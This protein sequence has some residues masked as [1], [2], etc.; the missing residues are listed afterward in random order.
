MSVVD[1]TKDLIMF[2]DY[3]LQI[4]SM[5]INQLKL[6][7]KEEFKFLNEISLKDVQ[8]YWYTDKNK[9]VLGG[10]HFFSF[11]VIYINEVKNIGKKQWKFINKAQKVIQMFPVILHELCHYWQFKKNPVLYFF[12]QF[13]VI[14]NFT[15]EKQA[16]KIENYVYDNNKFMNM[17]FK[18]IAQLKQKYNFSSL[19]FDE[20]E[21]EYLLS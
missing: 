13:P 7:E 4:I 14:R 17:S 16:Y 1:Y 8:I 20:K 19:Q 18:K 15:I 3:D 21:K 11:N 9:D 5:M 2:D 10:F 6:K 12:L